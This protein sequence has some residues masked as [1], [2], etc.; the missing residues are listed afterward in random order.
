MGDPDCPV[1][2]QVSRRELV[3]WGLFSGFG[4]PLL[5]GG[6]LIGLFLITRKRGHEPEE[7]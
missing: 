7:K 4:T 2:G 5:I 3:K 1:H 6:G